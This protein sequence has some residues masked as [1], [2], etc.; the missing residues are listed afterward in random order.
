VN[1]ARP[2]AAQV[3]F[4]ALEGV[5]VKRGPPGTLGGKNTTA[6]WIHAVTRKPHEDYEAQ[7]D[8]QIGAYDQMRARAALNIPFGEYLQTR[9]AMLWEERDGYQENVFLDDEN[10]DAFDADDVGF[11]QHLRFMPTESFDLLLTYDYYEQK[12]NGSQIKLI[13]NPLGPTP[14]PSTNDT[15]TRFPPSLACAIRLDLNKDLTVA[16]LTPTPADESVLME[17]DKI[18]VDYP[19]TRD[20]LFWGLTSTGTWD[21]PALPWLGETAL[22]GITSFHSTDISGRQDFDG[23]NL[24]LQKMQRTSDSE[25]HSAELQWSSSAGELLD[26]QLSL[27]YMHEESDYEVDFDRYVHHLYTGKAYFEAFDAWEETDSKS[28]GAAFHT[29]WYLPHDL[30][31][32]LGGRYTKDVKRV[33]YLRDYSQLGENQLKLLHCEGGAEDANRDFN[34]DVT[35]RVW[36]PELGRWVTVTRELTVPSCKETYRHPSG[37]ITLEWRP[38]EESL[39]YASAKRGYKSGGFNHLAYGTYDPEYIRAYALG[40]KNTFF[41]GRLQLNGELFYYDYTDLQL[42][43]ID[44]YSLRT[45]NSDARVSGVDLEVLAM[46]F[47]GMRLNA[48]VSYLDTELIDYVS[49][50]PTDLENSKLRDLCQI[51]EYYCQA[52]GTGEWTDYSG[53]QLSRAP[54]WSFTLGAEYTLFLGR[55]G[56]LTPRIQYYWQ[57]ET[58]YRAFNADL[59]YQESYHMTDLKL[60]WNSPSELWEVELFVNNLED[61]LIYHNVLVG[62]RWTGSPHFAWYGNPRVW[63]VRAGFRY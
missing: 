1:Y 7:A 12:G 40:A 38:G 34:P 11:R 50:D 63:G 19:P 44:G 45:E 41:D 53:N 30:T 46:P 55:W 49:I 27:F 59:D 23:T 37:G 31:L 35:K 56:S 33:Y 43:T 13:P 32:S 25:Q 3:A 17:P 36:N 57:D 18:K 47:E 22:K 16:A 10:R 15:L 60:I 2:E 5:Q 4:F 61:D 58:Y 9:I 8:F 6:G 52:Y 54:E 42:V 29:A 14:C 26:W 48:Q 39:V 62:S 51:R 24:D 28:Y 20:N 21:L